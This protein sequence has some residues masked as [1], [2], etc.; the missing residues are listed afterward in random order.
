LLGW[1]CAQIPFP[2]R[3]IPMRAER[4]AK[5][6]EA[7]LTGISQRGLSL[8]E[9]QPKLGHHR[10]RPRQRLGRTTATEDDESSSGRESHPSALTEPDV[11]LLRHPALT[12]QPPASHR[13]PTRQTTW[14]PGARCAPASAST[15]ALGV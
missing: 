6:R 3:L 7:L 11:T 10:L 15:H 8:I 1:A 4:V 12:P 5:E 14:G 9:R 13:V 2:V